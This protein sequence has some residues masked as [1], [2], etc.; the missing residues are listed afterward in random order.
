[1][2]GDA[3][4]RVKCGTHGDRTPAV[5]CRHHLESRDEVV[6]FV[7]NSADPDDL[8]AWCD[9]CEQVFLAEDGLTETFRRFNDF[10]VVCDFCYA[11]LRDRHTHLEG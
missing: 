10:R 6:G 11:S 9:A 3:K 7:E 4:H 1:M 5:V 8:Q 2:T